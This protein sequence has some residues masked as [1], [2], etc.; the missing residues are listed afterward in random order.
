[1]S[2]EHSCSPPLTSIG[3]LHT[4]SNGETQVSKL[5]DL[6]RPHYFIDEKSVGCM[7]VTSTFS[8]SLLACSALITS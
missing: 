5:R 8:T 2:R 4:E 3:I 1:M 6:G 7:Y